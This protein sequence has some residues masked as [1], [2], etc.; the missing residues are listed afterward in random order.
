MMVWGLIFSLVTVTKLAVAF[1]YDDTLVFSAPAFAKAFSA[2][3]QPFSP[4]FWGIVNSS[5]DLERPKV[6]GCG[7]AW[8]FKLCGFRVTIVTSRPPIANEALKKEWRHLASAKN[9]IFAGEKNAKHTYLENGNYVL[10]F[11]DSDSDMSEAK[12]AHVLPIRIRRSPKSAA[13]EDYHPG[14]LGELVIP[15]SEY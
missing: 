9:F 8:L 15:L 11:G 4:Q 2:V 6:S 12:L 1:D 5:Y 10:F 3:S 14:T 7:L 13:K